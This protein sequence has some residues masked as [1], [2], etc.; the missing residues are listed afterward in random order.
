MSDNGVWAVDH[1]VTAAP[2]NV[3]DRIAEWLDEKKIHT[4]FGIIGEEIVRSLRPLPKRTKLRSSAATW[5]KRRQ[6]RPA[7]SIALKAGSVQWC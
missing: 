4:A 2:M 6:W 3:A 1:L 7:T 5:S